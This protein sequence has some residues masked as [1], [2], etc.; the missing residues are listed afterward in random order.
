MRLLSILVSFTATTA[1]RGRRLTGLRILFCSKDVIHAG[2]KQQDNE[3]YQIS[4]AV[5]CPRSYQPAGENRTLVDKTEFVPKRVYAIKTA[6]TPGLCFDRPKDR[7]VRSSAHAL[8]TFIEILYREV[9]MVRIRFG[10]P[11]IAVGP[12]I[13]ACQDGAATSEIMP[14]RGD[15]SSWLLQDSGVI[16]RGVPDTGNGKNHTE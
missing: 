2:I 1:S 14:A 10:V 16:G 8:V 11:V 3:T 6:F 4:G 13:E 15:P 5:K 12:R 9:H 7:A